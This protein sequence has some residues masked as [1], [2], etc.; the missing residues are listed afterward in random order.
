MTGDGGGRRQDSPA[1]DEATRSI[2]RRPRHDVV[3]GLSFVLWVMS[4][5]RTCRD[6]DRK[7]SL[8][9]RI[10]PGEKCL[11]L[12]CFESADD[13]LEFLLPRSLTF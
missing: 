6:H 2:S 10:C 8:G 11:Q 9:R 4:V 12:N 3:A 5:T 1:A 7:S 13:T